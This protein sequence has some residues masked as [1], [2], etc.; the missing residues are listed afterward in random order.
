MSMQQGEKPVVRQCRCG[1]YGVEPKAILLRQEAR[2]KAMQMR[3]CLQG[4][5]GWQ[6]GARGDSLT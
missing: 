1:R 6:L 5:A 4:N 3:Q 2:D